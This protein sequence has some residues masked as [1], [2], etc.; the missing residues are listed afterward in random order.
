LIAKLKRHPLT[1]AIRPDKATLAALGATLV[2]FALGEAEREVPVWRMIAATAAEIEE[3]ARDVIAN[4]EERGSGWEIGDGRSAVG[5]G[6][7]PGETLPTRVLLS[8]PGLDAERLSAR[9]RSFSPAVVTRI[10]RGRLV[11]DLRTVRPVEDGALWML[12]ALALDELSENAGG[13][14]AAL[15]DDRTPGHSA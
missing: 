6:S 11:L 10:E 12:L 15:I 1:R 9:L 4:L 5:G 2:H 14:D 13:S 7:L 8:P 3:R